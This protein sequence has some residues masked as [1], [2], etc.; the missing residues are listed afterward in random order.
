MIKVGET[1]VSVTY[2]YTRE[3]IQDGT[4]SMHRAKLLEEGYVYNTHFKNAFINESIDR[5]YE[6]TIKIKIM[7]AKRP[8]LSWYGLTNIGEIH[9]V[10]PM[11]GVAKVIVVTAFQ[12]TQ[13]IDI[14][15]HGFYV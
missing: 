1:A 8:D 15:I 3:Q 11:S 13:I 4:A 9:E 5:V 7:R 14:W 10:E 2:Q 12:A 6:K